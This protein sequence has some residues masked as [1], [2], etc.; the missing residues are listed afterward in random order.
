MLTNFIFSVNIVMPLFV[1]LSLGY[2]LKKLGFLNEAFLSVANRLVFYVA[3][4]ISLF[5]SISSSDINTLMDV[6]FIVLSVSLTLVS[7][8]LIWGVSLI[9]IKDKAVLGAF[10]QGAFRGNI[11][12]VGLPLLVNL[13]GDVGMARIAIF[14][15]FV[16]PLYN[17]FSIILLS[18]SSDS[19]E[20][21]KFKTLLFAIIKNPLV[22]SIF[23]GVVFVLLGIN[24]PIAIE[25]SVGL[26]SGM[27]TPLA[28]LCLGASMN[29]RGF[30][31]NFSYAVVS[32]VIKVAV[33]PVVFVI[34]GFV[35][36]FRGYD[37]AA[38][39]VL[40]GMPGAI[41]GHA[42]VIQM[43]GNEYVSG[44]IVV[45]STLMSLVSITILIYILRML[46][47]V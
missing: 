17:I 8:L 23:I 47:L 44:T 26:I 12:F 21:I 42:M 14:I 1:I 45:L 32:S 6:P 28:L 46:G 30:D 20:K 7:F 40:G 31:K 35:L 39:M 13:A 41:S 3:L 22:I 43:G 11:A 4:P 24:L 29:F 2:S 37:L 19:T 34:I 33:L 27:A 36:G 18:A 25:N 38:L 16:T 9:F 10:V 15:T 5:R